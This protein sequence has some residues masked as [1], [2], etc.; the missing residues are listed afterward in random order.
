MELNERYKQAIAEHIDST[1]ILTALEGY[2]SVRHVYNSAIKEIT[3]KLEILDE[4]FHTRY[5][6]NPIHNIESRLKSPVS[7]AR[8]LKKKGLPVSVESATQNLHDIAGVRIICPY[9]DDVYTVAGLLL[10]QSDITLVGKKDYIQS[11]KP[12]GYRS[13]HLTISVPVFFSDGG[14]DVTVE[15]QI[16]TIGMDFWASLDH[17]LRYKSFDTP[18]DAIIRLRDCAEDMARL[19]K[20]MQS[21]RSLCIKE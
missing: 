4:E 1:Q 19:D 2:A 10:S 16:R 6:H 5:D 14:K 11:P 3:T 9:I 20:E 15:V 18:G 8:K 17:E 13:L 21:I 7:V 12:N